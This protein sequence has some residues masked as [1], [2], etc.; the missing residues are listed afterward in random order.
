MDFARLLEIVGNEPVFE[1]G[2]LLAGISEPDSLSQQLSRWTKAGRIVQ[3]RRGLYA[4]AAP[5]Q[6][7]K[8]HP[9]LIAN[10]LVKSSY[11]SLHAALAY[12][13]LIPEYTPRTTSITTL[14]PGSWETPLGDF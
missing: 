12:Y 2:L 14:R 8:P 5:F 6:K 4:V 13:D 11:V 3:F 1:T 10:L 9:F 7:T